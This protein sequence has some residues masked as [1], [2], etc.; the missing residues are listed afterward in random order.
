VTTASGPYEPPQSVADEIRRQTIAGLLD[1]NDQLVKALELCREERDAYAAGGR[2]EK[3]A[4]LDA[5]ARLAAGRIELGQIR[6]RIGKLM[7]AM[8]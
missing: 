8:R 3:A 1:Q 2:A 6:A 4:R 7:E 5:E